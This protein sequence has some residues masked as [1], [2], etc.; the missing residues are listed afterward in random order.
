MQPVGSGRNTL[1]LAIRLH[2]PTGAG[3]GTPGTNSQPRRV[4]T[5]CSRVLLQGKLGSARVDQDQHSAVKQMERAHSWNVADFPRV[6]PCV[7]SISERITIQCGRRLLVAY[8]FSGFV[9][10]LALPG[11]SPALR[12]GPPGPQHGL[13]WPGWPGWSRGLHPKQLQIERRRRAPSP[14]RISMIE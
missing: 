14:L 13:A 4:P 8:I 12:A 5:S 1:R 2:F 6:K 9:G 3:A 7:R 11:L 10:Q